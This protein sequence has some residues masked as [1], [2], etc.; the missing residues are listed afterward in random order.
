MKRLKLFTTTILLLTAAITTHAQTWTQAAKALAND[1]ADYDDFGSSSS[2]SVDIDGDYAIVGARY[3]D[4]KGTDAGAAYIF[5]RSGSSWTQ[6]QKLTAS[7]GAKNSSFGWTVDIDGDY[8]IV[9]APHDIS[10][11]GA[12][13]IFVRSGTS[14]T[15]QQKLVSNDAH[16]GNQ[17]GRGLSIDG[18]DLIVGAYY[19]DDKATDAGAAYFFTRSGTTWTQQQKVTASDGGNGDNFGLDVSI[20]G[21]YAIIGA[22]KD[23]D[24]GTDAG[25]AYIFTRSGTTWTQQKK[26]LPYKA[27]ESFGWNVDIGGDY[28]IAGASTATDKGSY[29]GSAYIFV[30]SG[31]SWNQQKKL[32]ANDGAA[33]DAFGYSV[34]IDGNYAIVGAYRE[35]DKGTNAGAAYVFSRSGTSWTQQAKLM[36]NDG[37]ADDMLGS[38]VSIS[39]GDI[40]I[41]AP[42]D[43]D[44]G[45]NAGAAYFFSP[46]VCGSTNALPTTANTTYT[47][48]YKS[49]DANGW[50][51]YCSPDGKLLLSLDTA[52]SGAV[53]AA[54]DVQLKLGASKTKSH[55]ADGGMIKNADGYLLVDRM[56][57]VSPTTQP[58]G[59]VGVRYYFTDAE[60]NA[61]V[62]AA[63]SHTNS[64]GVSK[65][66]TIAAVTAMEFYKTSGTA[67]A[68]P[69]TSSTGLVLTNGSAAST[70][71]W[72]YA[73]KGTD[74]SAEFKV[75]SFS[76]GGGGA[77]AANTSLPVELLA[78]T[79]TQADQ[80]T[81]MLRWTTA[82]EINNNRFDIERSYDG[83][84]FEVVGDVA[85]NG[86][87]QHQIDYSYTDASV[88]KVQKT[89][90]YRLKQV[91]FDGSTEY[92]DVRVVRFDAVG[93]DMQLVAYPN[94]MNDELNVMVGLS[95]GESYQLE[96]TN[97]QGKL[98]HLENH[99]Y[100][101]GLHKL[102]TSAWNSG[103]YIV[104]VATEHATKHMKI[105]K[106]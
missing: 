18:D 2:S 52:G 99:T 81:A 60:Y 85:G 34:S 88:S 51:H 94:P 45:T 62:T 40:I 102:N 106:K 78:F 95:N 73:A 30:R 77:G 37:A 87:S 38:S 48:A 55:G 44:K 57:D 49:I 19:D 25:A 12:V 33:Y 83:R 20:N 104:R 80:H 53:V 92:S 61:L 46:P 50:T 86:N 101:N 74:H 27:G 82:T 35:D 42:G 67:F 47:G 58:T 59:E 11:T 36:A 75:T 29:S 6:Q 100:D 26:I 17:F 63:A 105:V 1:G 4:D 68:M 64:S 21:D 96:V 32:T 70:S 43:D 5:K 7:D 69:H 84:T 28:A 14:W 65:P 23:D 90:Y 54:D 56:W 41:G 39:E 16:A 8:A 98:V 93:N 103:M 15:Q 76:G 22:P 9:G 91:D 10:G 24:K 71:N 66:T 3:E 97:L 89:V 13:Y 31:T 79:A 72:L